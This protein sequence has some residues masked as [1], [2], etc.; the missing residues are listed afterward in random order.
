MG[1]CVGLYGCMCVISATNYGRVHE[2][3]CVLSPKP[4]MQS[5]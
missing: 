1:A 5:N 4:V 3:C 2:R